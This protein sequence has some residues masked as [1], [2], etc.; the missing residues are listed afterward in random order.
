MTDKL[1]GGSRKKSLALNSLVLSVLKLPELE[2]SGRLGKLETE[3]EV[4]EV[5]LCMKSRV[6]TQQQ[7]EDG[8]QC[9]SLWR[10]RQGSLPLLLASQRVSTS[11]FA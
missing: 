11:T 7:E 2:L 10:A 8:R 6:G 1:F 4:L 5:C 3:S 9:H